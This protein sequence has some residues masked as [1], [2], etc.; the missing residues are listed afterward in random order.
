MEYKAR[1]VLIKTLEER[2]NWKREDIDFLYRFQ[3]EELLRIER[4]HAAYV[5]ALNDEY[6]NPENGHAYS[7]GEDYEL[8]YEQEYKRYL[9]LLKL[10]D[11]RL[12]GNI[13]E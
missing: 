6:D 1:E 2:F 10:I 11:S 5:A 3:L 8:E 12:V 4:D 9:N 7:R 13:E